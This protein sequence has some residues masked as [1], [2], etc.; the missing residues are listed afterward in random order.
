MLKIEINEPCLIFMRNEGTT[1][2]FQEKKKN[3][4][5][6]HTTQNPILM[7]NFYLIVWGNILRLLWHIS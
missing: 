1:L 5:P 3:F 2:L 7:D 4:V 6:T